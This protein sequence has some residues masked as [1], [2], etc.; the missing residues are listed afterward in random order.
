MHCTSAKVTFEISSVTISGIIVASSGILLA[1]HG[2]FGAFNW[3]ILFSCSIGYTW[4]LDKE[5]GIHLH[6]TVFKCG[7]IA[8][9]V[10]LSSL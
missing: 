6:P 3:D 4:F 5:S 1:F 7:K 2:I 9:D 8:D 10:A